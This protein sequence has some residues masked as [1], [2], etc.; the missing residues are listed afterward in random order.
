[1]CAV[2]KV[3]I[4]KKTVGLHLDVHVGLLDFS[5]VMPDLKFQVPYLRPGCIRPN[6]NPAY[7]KPCVLVPIMEV[8][9]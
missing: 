1:V 8:A 7:V 5:L 3:Q 2:S 4:S 6:L 9:I